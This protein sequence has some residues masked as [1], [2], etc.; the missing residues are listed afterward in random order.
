MLSGNIT[1]PAATSPADNPANATASL[2]QTGMD[3]TSTVMAATI[4]SLLVVAGIGA[5]LIRR[6]QL[7]NMSE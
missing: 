6:R 5:L 3:N 7:N 1:I 2:S 4:S